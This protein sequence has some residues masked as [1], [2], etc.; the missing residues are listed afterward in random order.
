MNK[1]HLGFYTWPDKPI[2][3][4]PS[5][6]QPRLDSAEQVM[7]ISEMGTLILT[8]ITQDMPEA[9]RLVFRFFRDEARVK[10][11]MEFLSLENKK[12]QDRFDVERL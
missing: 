9:E 12:G 4:A 1:A 8:M 3:Y 5:A 7:M 11:L 6:Q 10:K 2:V